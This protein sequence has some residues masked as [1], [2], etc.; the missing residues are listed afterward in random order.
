MNLGNILFLG[1]GASAVCFATWGVAV[2][3]LGAVKTSVYIY[4]SPVI[5]L[6]ASTLVLHEPVTWIAL[7]G[8]A[9]TLV[10]LCLSE[11]PWKNFRKNIVFSKTA[12]SSKKP[13]KK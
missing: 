11:A 12:H 13:E 10:G 7:L 9:F 3:R 6:I 5:T 4:L 2:K 1:L 8:A